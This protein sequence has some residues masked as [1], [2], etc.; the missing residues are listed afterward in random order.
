M[1]P[2]RGLATAE[3]FMDSVGADPVGSQ[4]KLRT[5]LMVAF[6][7][8]LTTRPYDP[9]QPGAS[10]VCVA[11]WLFGCVAVWR[12]ADFDDTNPYTQVLDSQ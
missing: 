3:A 10:Q 8:S 9:T 5:T 11:G 4:G 12:G 1:I 2:G 6:W 7:D